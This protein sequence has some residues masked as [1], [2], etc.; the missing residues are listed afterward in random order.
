MGAF[1][2]VNILPMLN[3]IGVESPG[4]PASNPAGYGGIGDF[5]STQNDFPP[6]GDV[7]VQAFGQSVPFFIPAAGSSQKSVMQLV[8]DT[9]I[10]LP[11]ARDTA[12]WLLGAGVFQN[13]YTTITFNYAN[14][15]PVTQSLSIAPWCFPPEPDV[16]IAFR[17]AA[18]DPQAQPAGLR[19]G[20]DA[21]RVPTNPSVVLNSVTLGNNPLV[22]LS[23]VTIQKA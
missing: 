5:L 17:G 14:V 10:P 12:V 8:G 18:L 2:E 4:V 9:T 11:A 7:T 3:R 1:Y 19:C 21:I 23:A 6:R 15:A 16:V 13:Q 22:G 20:Q